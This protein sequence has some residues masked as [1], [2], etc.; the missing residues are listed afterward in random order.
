MTPGSKGKLVVVSGPSGV[1]K[2][3][4]DKQALAR[5][6]AEFSVSA[7]TRPPRHGEVDGREYH[8]VTRATF[9]KMIADDRLLE[10]AEVFGNYY[11][12]PAEP[13]RQAMA[14]GRTILLE[15][16]IQGGLQVHR[17]MP[18][19]TFVLIVP[20][21]MDEL[22][23]RL[24]ERKTEDAESLARRLAKAQQELT[25][26]RQSGAYT[27]EIVNDELFRAVDELLDILTNGTTTQRR[28]TG[29]TP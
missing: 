4:I 24:I 21:S 9:E 13:V 28:I 17:R 10:Y 18:E 8:F 23:R 26:A 7:T 6:D 15:I 2:S 1:G 29:E 16:D 3:T 5:C 14:D 22:K 20:P 12:T 25:T 27:H 11:G 19:A